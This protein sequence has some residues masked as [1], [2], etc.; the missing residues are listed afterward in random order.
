MH[1]ILKLFLVLLLIISFV[2]PFIIIPRPT[3]A[4]SPEI[5]LAVCTGAGLLTNYLTGLL[6]ELVTTGLTV[7]V[8]EGSL[9][10]KEG[11]LDV[12]A[13]CAARQLFDRSI[14]GM[15]NIVRTAGRDGSAAYVKDWRNFLTSAEYRGEDVFRAILSNTKLCDY[16]DKDIKGIFGVTK[17]ISLPANFQARTG[18][19]DPYQLRANCTLPSSF[20]ITNYKKD[21]AANGGW[22]A[23]N[24]LLEPQNNFYGAL[25]ASLDETAR[26]RALESS[27]DTNEGVSGDGYTSKRKACQTTGSGSRCTILGTI[28]TPGSTLSGA[29]NASFQNEL[30]WLASSDELNE[31]IATLVERFVNRLLDIGAPD[32]EQ[33]YGSDPKTPRGGG[34]GGGGDG[35][36][37][38]NG[39][40]TPNYSG[41]LINAINIVI[42]ANA[43]GIADEL[44]TEENG[45]IILS[46]VA[47]ALQQTGYNATTNVKNGND[48]PNRGDLIAVWRSGDTTIERYDAI[49][50]SG[51]GNQPLRNVMG[52]NFVGDI[53]LSCVN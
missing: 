41:A 47:T 36:C 3:K 29:V 17:K 44:N 20:S 25:F 30:D 5:S 28:L 26:Q 33:K 8:S 35:E 11:V 48:N 42:D 6:K 34:G 49:T 12:V 39:D 45:F 19:F 40:G 43:G 53:P 37:A 4:A 50:D 13:R 21:F 14:T 23:W 15:L 7:P 9:R 24:R 2:V 46:Y 16:I 52:A 27:A 10:N 18:N 32:A 31:V 22:E 1:K 38:D 51:A